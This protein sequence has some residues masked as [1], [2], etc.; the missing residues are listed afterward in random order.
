MAITVNLIPGAHYVATIRLSGFET[1]AS[2]GMIASKLQ[3]AAGPWERLTISGGG[4]SRSAS[5]TYRGDARA[6]TLPAQVS[7]VKSSPPNA[8]AK[9]D[10]SVTPAPVAAAA[11]SARP[12]SPEHAQLP[13]DNVLH[14][15]N[16]DE[17][18]QT[19]RVFSV[20]L[21]GSAALWLL[22]THDAMRRR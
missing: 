11:S 15:A 17:V 20:V 22:T 3:S 12:A 10:A 19:W 6:V 21:A 9:P 4:G 1:L 16:T 8:A 18:A 14:A 7:A 2:N 13:T 5:G